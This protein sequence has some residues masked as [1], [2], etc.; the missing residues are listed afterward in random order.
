MEKKSSA[1]DITWTTEAPRE[2]YRSG[3]WFWTVGGISLAIAV[4]ALLVHNW[5]FSILILLAGSTII[6]NA[7][8]KPLPTTCTINSRGVVVNKQFFPYN[9]LT[10]FWIEDE[11]NPTLILHVAGALVPRL[12]VPIAPEVNLPRLQETLEVHIPEKRHEKTF[13]EIIGERLGI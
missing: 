5:L 2:I 4:A 3:D 12:W 1:K 13:A 9:N 7:I 10:S 8:K 11:G 6:L